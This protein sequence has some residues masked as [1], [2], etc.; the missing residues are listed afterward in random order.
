MDTLLAEKPKKKGRPAKV[1]DVQE[2]IVEVIKEVLI[3][4]VVEVPKK[5]LMGFDLY[6]KLKDGRYPQGGQGDWWENPNGTDR[7]YVPR[8][9]ELYTHF[10]GD[11]DAWNKLRDVLARAWL[12][13]SL[14]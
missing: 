6:K 1:A 10:L 8:P 7:V 4:K 12:E 14:R 3:E 2:Q 13:L 5:E 11:P 9:E